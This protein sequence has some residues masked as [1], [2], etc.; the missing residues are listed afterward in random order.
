MVVHDYQQPPSEALSN[1]YTHPFLSNPYTPRRANERCLYAIAPFCS[2][3]FECLKLNTKHLHNSVAHIH[4]H[5]ETPTQLNSPNN[6]NSTEEAD[7][8]TPPPTPIL[9]QTPSGTELT[10]LDGKIDGDIR[11]PFTNHHQYYPI[12][13]VIDAENEPVCL[14]SLY[15]STEDELHRRPS[16]LLRNGTICRMCRNTIRLQ[17][18]EH[19]K[20]L[21]SKRLTLAKDIIVNRVDTHYLNL[22][23][24]PTCI[25]DPYTPESVESHSPLPDDDKI[26]EANDVDQIPSAVTVERDESKVPSATGSTKS[27]SRAVSPGQ[28][29]SRLESLQSTKSTKP[30][31]TTVTVVEPEPE[32]QKENMPKGCFERYCRII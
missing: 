18:T 13:N 30:N 26:D 17:P 22:S 16:D 25:P 20:T 19:R 9:R 27:A 24:Y 4:S 2:I 6:G 10:A 7:V 31:A 28:L 32:S 29:K 21:I 12:I 15:T 3:L 5:P 14:C 11:S 23:A 1:P 8:V